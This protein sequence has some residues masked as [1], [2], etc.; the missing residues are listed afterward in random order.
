MEGVSLWIITFAIVFSMVMAV[1]SIFFSLRAMEN[2]ES[3]VRNARL[4]AGVSDLAADLA[5][6]SDT[7]ARQATALRKIRNRMNADDA[8]GAPR[9]SGRLSDEEFLRQVDLGA[10]K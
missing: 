5:V 7:V 10:I 1:V 2:A 6:L 9:E 8:R 4:K 3:S